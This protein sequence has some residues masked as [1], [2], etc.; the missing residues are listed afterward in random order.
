FFRTRMLSMYGDEHLKIRTCV[1]GHFGLGHAYA[2]QARPDE[3]RQEFEVAARSL[4]TLRDY[5]TSYSATWFD[6]Y[7]TIYVH[8]A[9]LLAERARIASTASVSWRK[10]A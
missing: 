5:L 8:Q 2:L 6:F 4:A 1:S 10:S 7:L 3:A 9:E